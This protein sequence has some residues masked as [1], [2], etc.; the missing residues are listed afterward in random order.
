MI[1]RIRPFHRVRAQE[2]TLLFDEELEMRVQMNRS[3]LGRFRQ[4]LEP[5]A[6]SSHRVQQ[7]AAGGNP[8]GTVHRLQARLDPD[9]VPD[10]GP[11][12]AGQLPKP[13]VGLRGFEDGPVD[14]AALEFLGPLVGVGLVALLPPALRNRRHDEL[15]DMGPEDLVEPGE[16]SLARLPYAA[17]SSAVSSETFSNKSS[18]LLV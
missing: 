1:N 15:V 2:K 6:A 4:L 3:A 7:Q 5:L 9:A 12:A 10:R 13:G 18:K 14:R 16:F 17:T 8:P 11:M